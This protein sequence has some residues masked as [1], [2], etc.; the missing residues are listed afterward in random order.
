M[1]RNYRTM[2]LGFPPFTRAVK[3]LIAING[4]IF[5]LL[6]LLQVTTPQLYGE[7]MLLFAL[8]PGAVIQGQVWQLVTYSFLHAGLFHLLFNMLALWMFGSQFES[9]WGR[10]RF[11]E[12]FFFCVVGAALVTVGVAYTGA[13]GLG[14]NT[15]TIGASGGIYGILLAFGMLYGEREIMLFP[16]PFMIKAKYFVAGL[17]FIAVYGALQGPGGVANLAHLGGLIFG[18]IYLKLLPRRGLIFG[19][20]ENYFGIRNAYYRWKRRRAARKFQVYMS[21]HD[22]SQFF[23]EHGNYREPGAT[24]REKGN[25]EHRGPWVQ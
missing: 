7:I 6:A 16:I 11:L 10:R 20:S 5:L 18:L 17:T 21:K 25:G 12:F 1:A 9:E 8:V 19:A 3:W 22:R 23:D 13:L 4:I 15:I 24:P 14:P 2:S